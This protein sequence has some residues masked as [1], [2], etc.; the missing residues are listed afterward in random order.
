MLYVQGV[1]NKAFNYVEQLFVPI[2]CTASNRLAIQSL[3]QKLWMLCY[4][5]M[6]L[7]GKIDASHQ[8]D[9]G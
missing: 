5:D 6:V 2:S 8:Q 1:I 7:I 4:I 9:H 3:L